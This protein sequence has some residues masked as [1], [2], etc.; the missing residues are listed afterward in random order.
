MCVKQVSFVMK[1]SP[2]GSG[3]LKT[4]NL[5]LGCAALITIST[6][7]ANA[8]TAGCNTNVWDAMAERAEAQLLYDVAV[9]EEIIEQPDSV[10]MLTC[11]DNSLRVTAQNGGRIFSGAFENR[12]QDV[13][14]DATD[15]FVAD[16]FDYAEG[17]DIGGTD[18]YGATE[19]SASTASTTNSAPVGVSPEND[20]GSLTGFSPNPANPSAG[21]ACD[22]MQQVWDDVMDGGINSDVTYYTFDDLV[23]SASGLGTATAFATNLSAHASII[24]NADASI[25]AL[26]VPVVPDF[27][28]SL[29]LADVLT[30]AGITP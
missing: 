21:Y 30:D 8:V 1:K 14:G 23:T 12:M 15:A 16:N 10:L 13:V 4:L 27:T 25:T 2:I 5:F 11:F 24:T 9:L 19:F 7:P 18:Y 26:P 17:R 29:T 3:L 20:L 22:H 28:A 6:S